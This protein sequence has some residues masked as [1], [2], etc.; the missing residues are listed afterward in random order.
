MCHRVW[1]TIVP[2]G[3]PGDPFA[4]SVGPPHGRADAARRVRTATASSHAAEPG[5]RNRD[6]EAHTQRAACEVR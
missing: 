5:E 4:L 6:E 1:E 2:P 3:C